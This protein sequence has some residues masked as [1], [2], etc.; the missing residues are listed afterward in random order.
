SLDCVAAW[1]APADRPAPPGAGGAPTSPEGC[2]GPGVTCGWAC[3]C[4]A[5]GVAG[6]CGGCFRPEKN[7]PPNST[8]T[9]KAMARIKLR[10]FSSMSLS[11]LAAWPRGQN[12]Q[13]L[14]KSCLKAFDAV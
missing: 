1:G 14:Y 2:G 7:F 13:S 10:L 3:C 5:V 4:C 8:A 11:Q 9:G 6:G 12:G